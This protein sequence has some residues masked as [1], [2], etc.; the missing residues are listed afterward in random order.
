M[1]AHI[2]TP[3]EKP[4][5]QSAWKIW[6]ASFAFLALFWLGIR[7]IYSYFNTMIDHSTRNTGFQVEQAAAPVVLLLEPVN[8]V[9]NG[10]TKTVSPAT[11]AHQSVRMP[12][13]PKQSPHRLAPEMLLLH[14]VGG[15]ILLALYP[16]VAP[17]TVKQILTWARLGVFDTTHF[18][19]LEPGFVLQTSLAEDRIIPFTPAQ[20]QSLGTI[21][22]EFSTTLKHR[23]GVLSMGRDDGK[24]DSARTSFSILLGDAPHLDGQYTIFGEVEAGMEVVERLCTAPRVDGSNAPE[25]RLTILNVQVVHQDELSLVKM[26]QPVELA[27]LQQ[28]VWPRQAVLASAA[29]IL[30]K[31]CWKCHGGES[32]KGQLDLTCSTGLKAGGEHGPV[33]LPND[34]LK[35]ALLHRLTADDDQRMPPKGPTLHAEEIRILTEWLNHG[36]EYPPDYAL[37]KQ[38]AS[39]PDHALLIASHW[40]FQPLSAVKAP[41]IKQADWKRNDTDA[42]ILSKLESRK[43]S[44]APDASA[45]VLRRRLAYTLTGLPPAADQQGTHEQQVEQ[46][47]KSSHYGEHMAR[48]WLDLVRFAESDGYE[49]DNNR[50]EAYHYRDFLIRAF[51]DDLPF[52]QFLRWQLA[53]DELAPLQ[54]DARAATG[55]LAAGPFQTFFAKKKDRYDE[56]DDIVTT[57]SVAFMGM[58]VGCARCHD[59]KH[60]PV[61][62]HEYYRMVSVFHGSRRKVDYLDTEAGRMYDQQREPLAKLLQEFADLTAPAREK[63]RHQKIAALMIEPREKAVLKLP[64]DPDNGFQVS[65]LRRYD[66]LLQ[67]TTDE[68]RQ[69]CEEQHAAAWDEL[70][71]KIQEEESK[72]PPAP[73]KGLIYLGSRTE[74]ASFLDRGDP[75]RA[76]HTVPPGF[77]TALTPSRPVW[78]QATWQAWGISPRSALANWLTDTDAGAGHQVARVIV[79]R[80]WQMHFGVGLVKTANDFGITGT[81]PTHPE[82]L[83]YLA[84]QLIQNGW[85]LKPIHQLIV[86]SHTWQLSQLPSEELKKADPDNM[87]YGRRIMQRLTA[88]EVRDSI[89]MLTGQL[90]RELFG[91]SIKPAIPAEAIF[92]TAPKHGEVWPAVVPEQPD[93]WRRSL[94]IYRK[95][96]N[97]VPF[98]QLFDAPDAAS[99]CACRVSS[100]TPTQSLA[101]FNNPFIRHQARHAARQALEKTAI[102]PAEAVR[103][104]Y[105]QLLSREVTTVELQRVLQFIRSR[106]PISSS[107]ALEEAMTDICHTLFMTNEFLYVE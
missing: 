23:K 32:T 45:P 102:N 96:S 105:R 19:R 8:E 1:K 73:A 107:V 95:R 34:P 99:S 79:N 50:P 28:Q 59:H 103:L 76:R 40:F 58:T 55:F 83:D 94:Y 27:I 78:Q 70:A 36:A 75:D 20:Q 87:L 35:S 53:G 31:H 93:V 71:Q 91:P 92:A 11:T 82:L 9:G 57:S 30:K 29:T 86:T 47:L 46:L 66:Y 6:L 106:E 64:H 98:L 38:Q 72:L 63:V 97:P 13:K 41:D 43:L 10:P 4:R 69:A 51:N 54:S 37:R 81:P 25:T 2:S 80:L 88:E 52:D 65:L 68:A 48:M 77:L 24:P 56:L 17:K 100:T 104:V 3:P 60:D 22:G 12:S 62:Q 44:P 16:D 85:K 14:T 61:T 26:E 84:R 39:A 15:D 5:R 67:V 42:F 101:L 89:L 21:P 49:D 7:Y 18:S 33:F 90:N 74:P